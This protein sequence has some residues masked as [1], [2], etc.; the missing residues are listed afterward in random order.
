MSKESLPIKLRGDLIR[1]DSKVFTENSY[2]CDE[3]S[4]S[5]CKRGGKQNAFGVGISLKKGKVKVT[6][7]TSWKS[8]D[9]KIVNIISGKLV[10]M[11]YGDRK[12]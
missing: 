10:Y 8:F 9:L 4:E 12:F 11:G 2:S 6:F 3:E 5:G 1:I 7:T